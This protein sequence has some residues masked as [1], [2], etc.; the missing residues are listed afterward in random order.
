M[1]APTII[2]SAILCQHTQ[3]GISNGRSAACEIATI[4]ANRASKVEVAATSLA[5]DHA[6]R[7]GVPDRHPCIEHRFGAT[8]RHKNMSVTIAPAAIDTKRPR[9]TVILLAADQLFK[10]HRACRANEPIMKRL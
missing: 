9:H 7:R 6:K 10:A 5:D 4:D 1:P 2:K 3:Y 8:R